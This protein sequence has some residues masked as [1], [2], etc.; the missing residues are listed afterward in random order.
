MSI[1]PDTAMIET[2][3]SPSAADIAQAVQGK[4]ISALDATALFAL[5]REHLTRRLFIEGREP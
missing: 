2:S 3:V 1:Q 5:D 4:K